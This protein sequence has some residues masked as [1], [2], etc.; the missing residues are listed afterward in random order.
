MNILIF[1]LHASGKNCKSLPMETKIAKIISFITHPLLI[2]TYAFLILLNLNVYFSLLLPFDAKLILVL[3]IFS[4]TFMLPSLMIL[5]FL[6]NSIISSL[7]METKQERIYPFIT[8]AVFFYVAC[9]LLK[10]LPFLSVFCIFLRGTTFLIIL[11]II[12][13]FFWKIS[14]HMVGIG[15]ML[16]TFAGLS[17]RLA[18]DMDYIIISLILISG[19]IGYAR[20]KMGAHNSAQIYTGWLTGAAAAAFFVFI[21]AYLFVIL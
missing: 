21:E 9:F 8:T 13:N 3:G 15:G 20:L 11:V 1:L 5:L 17:Y 10:Q 18:M 6:K 2:P 19:I 12:I 4:V 7:Q 16:G 14:V